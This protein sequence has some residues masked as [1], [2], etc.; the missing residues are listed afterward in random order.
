M[1]DFCHKNRHDG[2]NATMNN[3]P[4]PTVDIIIEIKDRIVLIER[5]FKPFGWAIPGGFVEYGETV[6]SCARREAMEET[7]LDI[8]IIHLL[9]VYSDPVRDPRQHTVS[10]VF[11]AR[12]AGT[13]CA[14]DDAKSAG[15]F[16][17][18]S[19]PEPVIFDHSKIL[20]DYFLWKKDP[21]FEFPYYS[22]H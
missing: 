13:P 10:T 17:E 21:H 18:D 1:T 5:R 19:L 15:L 7:S 2:G 14:G 6:Q 3:H 8:T 16:D 4:Y 20:N 11:I 22:A 12:A 9:G